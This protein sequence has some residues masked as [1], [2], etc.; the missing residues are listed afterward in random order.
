MCR[1]NSRPRSQSSS[2]IPSWS[3]R[4]EGRGLRRRWCSVT[5]VAPNCTQAPMPS[6]G[7]SSIARATIA[8]INVVLKSL[9]DVTERAPTGFS[10]NRRSAPNHSE[11]TQR[12]GG[13]ARRSR[14]VLAGHR[15]LRSRQSIAAT[16]PDRRHRQNRV[17]DRSDM[18]DE[19]RLL[20]WPAFANSS[21]V[22]RLASTGPYSTSPSS[23]A[24][25]TAAGCRATVAR[26]TCQTHPACWPST[27]CCVNTRR[28]DGRHG[29]RPTSCTPARRSSARREPSD[30]ARHEAHHPSGS[31]VL[32]ATHQDRHQRRQRSPKNGKVP[33]TV[34][35]RPR[36][37]RA[38]T[39]RHC[40]QR[41]WLT[42]E[43]DTRNLRG[44]KAGLGNLRG[45]LRT[46]IGSNL[47]DRP[48]PGQLFLGRGT[49]QA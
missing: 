44:H 2:A 29:P 4:P 28:A 34:R 7:P 3:P 36:S 18:G 6:E 15:H 22:D 17:A 43:F 41:R 39:L 5:D 48:T 32:Q 14:C 46:L 42:R 24:S 8:S 20:T 9:T 13:V 11:P 45:T 30:G 23:T 33:R 37:T 21:R 27:H 25:H 35:H 26:R 10:R 38:C 16:T 31:E 49:Y 12:P 1:K 19:G 47:P 40:A